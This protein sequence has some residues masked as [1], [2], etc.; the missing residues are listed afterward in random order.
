MATTLNL[1]D[2]TTTVSLNSSGIT[3]LD[4][5]TPGTPQLNEN[6]VE[7]L[8]DGDTLGTPTWRNVT[9]SIPLLLA[10][11]A[12]TI[13]AALQSLE[14]LLDTA[15]QNRLTSGNRRVYLQVQF[16]H[17]T[18]VWRSEV[19]AGRAVPVDSASRL[20]RGTLEVSLL[21]TRRYYWEGAETQLALTS[22]AT[23]PA[24]TDYVD[25]YNNDDTT[26]AATNW[27]Q[28]ASTQVT[29]DLPTP[30]KLEIKNA[31]GGLLYARGVFVGNYVW[32]DP[33]TVDPI[34]RHGDAT[35]STTTLSNGNET[36]VYRWAVSAA[37]LADFDGQYA[38]L[39]AAWNSDPKSDTLFRFALQY[40]DD[41]AYIDL[42]QG[43]Q[44]VAGDEVI[45]DLG[46][47]PVPP[48]GV[49]A[50]GGDLFLAIKA[51]ATSGS[52]SFSVDWVQLMPA[53]HGLFRHLRG[54][55]L[56][57]SIPNNDAIIDDGIAARTYA[58]I[59]GTPS[60]YYRAYHAPVH[61]WP[62]RT[63]RLRLMV[64]G[65]TTL[66]PAKLWQVKAWYRPRRL[67]V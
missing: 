61:V 11:N 36:T 14:M 22:S 62:N 41:G 23:S 38:R 65:H 39:L 19:L 25:V 5:W 7:N 51:Q 31:S 53:G 63:Q 35:T 12:A 24:T 26:P 55:A 30:L 50:V 34:W 2:G 3:T 6:T 43:E 27:F 16:D 48:G 46:A 42:T 32:M 64:Q 59:G 49:A 17:D 37:Q 10:G 58:R 9:E 66:E 15:R 20:Q 45:L 13:V 47:L 40:D 54:M 67:T 60:P 56:S 21:L 44:V 8:G 57:V 52:D 28:V 33:T 1:T 18:G 4:G 29:G